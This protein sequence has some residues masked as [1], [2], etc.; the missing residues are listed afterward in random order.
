M[1]PNISFVLTDVS[2]DQ[3]DRCRH[4]GAKSARVP[5]RSDDP[6]GIMSCNLRKIHELYLNNVSEADSVPDWTLP[7]TF[8]TYHLTYTIT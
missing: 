1:A 2:N 6:N 8:A 7:P 3:N 5:Q 4:F